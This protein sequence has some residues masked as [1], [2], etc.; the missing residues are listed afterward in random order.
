MN[1]QSGHVSTTPATT[2]LCLQISWKPD[3][4]HRNQLQVWTTCPKTSFTCWHIKDDQTK[5]DT[6]GAVAVELIHDLR[7]ASLQGLNTR[8]T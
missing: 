1:T 4:N 6:T 2:R 5:F 7:R 3:N 8:S